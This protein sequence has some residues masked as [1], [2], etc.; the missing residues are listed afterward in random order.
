MMR[1]PAQEP[2]P[3]KAK[4]Q[5]MQV[6]SQGHHKETPLRQTAEEN[7]TAITAELWT[8]GHMSTLT[9]QANSSNSFT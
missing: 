8:I 5:A 3:E 7:R 2:M 9:C 6:Q 4:V 1:L